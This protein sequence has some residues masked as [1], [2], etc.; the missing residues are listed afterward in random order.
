MLSYNDDE[1]RLASIDSRVSWSYRLRDEKETSCRSKRLIYF[2][3]RDG[4]SLQFFVMNSSG[5]IF[6]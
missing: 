4:M 5:T 2:V 3:L 1:D 6:T